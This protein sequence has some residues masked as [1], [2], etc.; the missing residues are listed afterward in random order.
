MSSNSST[1]YRWEHLSSSTEVSAASIELASRSARRTRAVGRRLAALVTAADVVYLIGPLG[2]GKT[3]VAKGIAEGLRLA[4]PREVLSPSYTLMRSYCGERELHHIDLYRIRK[5]ED[6]GEIVA[7]APHGILL[8]EWPER[9]EGYLPEPTWT[10]TLRIDDGCRHI[11][12]TGPPD[13][14]NGLRA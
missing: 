8:I 13:R 7:M 3:V 10:V 4:D 2:A 14:L 11:T 9:G 12:V 5:P 1:W 6:A